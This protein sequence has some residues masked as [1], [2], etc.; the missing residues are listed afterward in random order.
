MVNQLK[1]DEINWLLTL[2]EL[3]GLK[4]WGIASEADNSPTLFMLYHV[5]HQ[6]E[7]NCPQRKDFWT[8]RQKKNAREAQEG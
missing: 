6:R 5:V 7:K 3:L 4:I 1:Q 8:V 2:N